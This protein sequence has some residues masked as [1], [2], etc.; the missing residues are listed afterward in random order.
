[1]ACELCV[2]NDTQVTDR[3]FIL[4]QFTHK[5]NIAESDQLYS[6]YVIPL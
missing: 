1:M 5:I 2:F 4:P 3:Q 6:K